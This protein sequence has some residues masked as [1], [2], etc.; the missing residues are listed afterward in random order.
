MRL[1]ERFGALAVFAVLL[2]ALAGCS[3]N[4]P[5]PVCEACE[6][7]FRISTVL[8]RHPAPHPLDPSFVLFST[9]QKA[10]PNASDAARQDDEDIWL[11]WMESQDN[12]DSNAVVGRSLFAITDDDFSTTG[13]NTMPRWSPSGTRIAWVHAPVAGG[14]QI[15]V[16]PVQVPAARG[17]APVLGPP[18]MLVADAQDPAWL[19]E[20]RVL[21]TR[22]NKIF[23]IDVSGGP[24]SET[25][26]SFDPPRY[27]SNDD[28]I[29]RHPSVASDGAIVFGT[30]D[31][32]PVADVYVQAFEVIP[33]GATVETDAFI[34]YQSP[35][36]SQPTL[37][38][39]D[40]GVELR[41]PTL[42]KALP[43][44]SSQPYRIGATLA[45]FFVADSLR[46]SYCDTTIVIEKVFTPDTIDTVTI[47][48]EIVRATLQI[49]TDANNA[50][51]F[52]T[53]ADGRTS[54]NDFPGSPVV[55]RCQ[56]RTYDCLLPWAVDANGEIQVG[57]PEPFTVS[58][59]SGDP[60]VQEVIE[61]I[62]LTP[63]DTTLVVVFD[64]PNT[65]CAAPAPRAVEPDPATVAARSGSPSLRA[66]GDASNVWRLE[67][68]ANGAAS[69]REL[70]ASSGLIQSPAV[71]REYPGG[72][73]YL[74]WSSDETGEWQLFV[75]RLANWEP[76]GSPHR[77][78][79]P[80]SLDNLACSRSVFHP[81][82]VDQ[83]SPGALRL[84]VTMTECPD[85][86][87]PDIGSDQDPWPI[88]ELRV[89]IVLVEDY[90]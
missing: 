44:E 9:V 88:G 59:T 77:V 61:G 2:V 38:V 66:P 65:A 79:V 43:I 32:L 62:T 11:T 5:T 56:R 70:V 19:S 29:D 71:T 3:S 76:Q 39:M 87:F 13:G 69:F 84:L 17:D 86:G 18:A 50:T 41:T 21:F 51:I 45:A 53:R 58:A 10:D 35:S 14:Y 25:Q 80:G 64:D 89:W 47:T 55:D 52:W 27:S 15:W 83:S 81:Q 48:F 74:A 7:W 34:S 8:G 6:Q 33:G 68:D 72:I 23:R 75:Q 28:Y 67:L 82:W 90:Q 42:M 20:D 37:P 78:V 36:A 22:A 60:P 46:E 57:V 31:R 54:I 26:V 73:R 16:M 12:A 1:L 4:D 85:N 63:G 49:E 30:R 40:Q 24:G